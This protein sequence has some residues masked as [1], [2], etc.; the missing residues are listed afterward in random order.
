M[1]TSDYDLPSSD[2]SAL[3]AMM[4]SV[5]IDMMARLMRKGCEKK[6]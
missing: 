3:K 4:K 5:G 6:T 2:M 1:L